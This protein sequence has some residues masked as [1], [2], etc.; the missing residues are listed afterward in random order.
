MTIEAARAHARGTDP[1]TSDRTV[2][3]IARDG[4]LS[5]HIWTI[6]KAYRVGGRPFNDTELTVMIEAATGQ[7]QQRNV[8]AR[9]RGLMEDAGLLRQAGIFPFQGRDLMHYEIHPNNP[10]EHSG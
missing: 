9:A 10:K 7:R 6:A 3:S 4:T 5:W 8:I 2:K 1:V